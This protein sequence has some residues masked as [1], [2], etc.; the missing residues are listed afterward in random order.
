MKLLFWGVLAAGF[1]GCTAFGI[2]PVLERM[3]G[4]W[5]SAP[6]LAGTGLGLAIVALAVMFGFGIRPGVLA[7]DVAMIGLL[8]VLIGAK[9]VVGMLA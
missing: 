4:N 6:M 2:G 5:M 9:V 8:A 3:G 1:A 7:S